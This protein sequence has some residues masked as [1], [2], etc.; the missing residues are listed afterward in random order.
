MRVYFF[1]RNSHDAVSLSRGKLYIV[2]KII[3]ICLRG[4]RWGYM[5]CAREYS[6]RRRKDLCIYRKKLHRVPNKCSGN[7]ALNEMD[8]LFETAE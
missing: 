2:L 3:R 1:N 7:I 4:D 8:P 5:P 6:S